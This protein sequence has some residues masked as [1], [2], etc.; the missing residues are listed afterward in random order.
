MSGG[1][2]YRLTS[3]ERAL[4]ADQLGVLEALRARLRPSGIEPK[5]FDPE[6]QV[7]AEENPQGPRFTLEY[8][9]D[10]DVIPN[11]GRIYVKDVFQLNPEA[12]SLL[13]FDRSLKQD[14]QSDKRVAFWVELARKDHPTAKIFSREEHMMRFL[15]DLEKLPKPG[16]SETSMQDFLGK[17]LN[18]LHR[19]FPPK[20]EALV[21][22]N[23]EVFRAVIEKTTPLGIRMKFGDPQSG[24]NLRRE[25]DM[26]GRLG[27]NSSRQ[28]TK[29]HD[30]TPHSSGS[31]RSGRKKTLRALLHHRSQQ[32]C[33]K[34]VR[35]NGF[36]PSHGLG[37]SR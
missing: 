23:L 28:R 25:G 9:F 30:V 13:S 36:R 24:L 2:K 20:N 37:N 4:F 31:K 21:R 19:P 22:K 12:G 8:P 33:A 7:H 16:V 17:V 35:Q 27:E 5:T 32:R 15:K 26:V 18:R 11:N 6:M 29:H 34:P 10:N 14:I 3:K 1:I